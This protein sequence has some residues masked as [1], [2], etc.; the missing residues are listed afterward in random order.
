MNDFKNVLL[1]RPPM[2]TDSYKLFCN[3]TIVYLS[4]ATLPISI[5]PG[6]LYIIKAFEDEGF[7]VIKNLSTCFMVIN[8]N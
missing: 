5:P 4:K 8:K 3:K 2:A 1:I 6:L 7:K